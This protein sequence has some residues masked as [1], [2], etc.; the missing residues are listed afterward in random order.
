MAEPLPIIVETNRIIREFAAETAEP[1]QTWQ[2]LC[3]CGCFELVSL[4]LEEFDVQA[5]VFAPG[6]SL[7]AV[8]DPEAC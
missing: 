5:H 8:E 6:H 3:E 4:R 1:S 2:F 7:T